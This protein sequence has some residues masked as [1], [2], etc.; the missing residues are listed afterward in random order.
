ME[1]PNPHVCKKLSTEDSTD[2]DML[3]T[4]DSTNHIVM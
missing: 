3:S 4:E 2:H 1:I